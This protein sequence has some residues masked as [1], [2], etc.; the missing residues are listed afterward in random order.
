MRVR[1]L[2]MTGAKPALLF[3]NA[4]PGDQGAYGAIGA[5][6]RFVQKS[7]ET[8]SWKVR[9]APSPRLDSSGMPQ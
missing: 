3:N 8:E 2:D 9:G 4:A 7:T 6:A 1:S 5:C